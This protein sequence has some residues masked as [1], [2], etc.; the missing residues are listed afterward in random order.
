MNYEEYASVDTVQW[1][2]P[3][4]PPRYKSARHD[5]KAIADRLRFNPSEWALVAKEVNPSTVTH[6][7]Q[8]RLTAFSPAGSYE[9]S[10]HGRTENGQTAELYVRY[11]GEPEKVIH[12]E[13]TDFSILDDPEA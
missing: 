3:P 11:V 4:A 1:K 6:I 10:G 7:R 12:E 13:S 9:A 5:W 2:E 8:G